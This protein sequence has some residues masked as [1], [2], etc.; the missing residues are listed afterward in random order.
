[1]QEEQVR[2]WLH[3]QVRVLRQTAPSSASGNGK[4]AA[5][6]QSARGEAESDSDEADDFDAPCAICGRTYYHV[7]KSAVRHG[8]RESD[9]SDSD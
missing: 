9:S 2:A 4:R 7:H 3:T 6:A 1:M 8:G 5:G